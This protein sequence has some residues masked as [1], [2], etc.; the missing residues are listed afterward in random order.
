MTRKMLM[1]LG[2]ALAVSSSPVLA[3][4][5]ENAQGQSCG[6]FTGTWHFVNNQN[7][8]TVTPLDAC[9]SSGCVSGVQASSNNKSV[10]HYFVIATGT[11]ISASNSSPGKIVLSDFSCESKTCVP[12]S[13]VEICGDGKDNDCNGQI[14]D[15]CKPQ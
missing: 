8:G 11:I 9:F 6:D 12:D 2:L 4:S 3:A 14:D 10:A 13:K 5:L 1:L 7:G 15:G